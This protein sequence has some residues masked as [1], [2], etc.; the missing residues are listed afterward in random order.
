LIQQSQPDRLAEYLSENP[1]VLA[2]IVA[3]SANKLREIQA[4]LLRFEEQLPVIGAAVA[5]FHIRYAGDQLRRMRLEAGWA[6][7]EAINHLEYSQ[8]DE[9]KQRDQGT[10]DPTA[11]QSSSAA[12]DIEGNPV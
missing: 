7:E 1:Q 6:L 11:S 10:Y 8:S 5:D 9:R 3:I 12:V 4:D 2:D